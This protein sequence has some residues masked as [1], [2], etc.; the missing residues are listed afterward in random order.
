MA[1]AAGMPADHAPGR[2]PGDVVLAQHPAP[3]SSGTTSK[4]LGPPAGVSANLPFDFVRS[5]AR[6]Q[7][8]VREDFA[9]VLEHDGPFEVGG[10]DEAAAISSQSIAASSFSSTSPTTT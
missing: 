3:T 8:R 10:Y 9:W 7:L 4:G 5:L 1:A 6:Q 2:V